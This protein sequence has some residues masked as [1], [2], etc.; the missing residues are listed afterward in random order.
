MY[1]IAN[2]DGVANVYRYAFGTGEIVQITNISTGTTGITFLSPALSVARNTGRVLFSV[3]ESGNYNVYAIEPEEIEPVAVK[4]DA[5]DIEYLGYLT[6]L[7]AVGE[8][9]VENYLAD[10]EDGLVAATEFPSQDYSPRLGLDFIGSTGFGISGGG[11]FGTRVFG[12]ASFFFSDML[13]DH[14]LFTAVQVQGT[15]R[16]IGGSVSYTNLSGR[17]NWGASVSRTPWLSGFTYLE[18]TD[19]GTVI[20][21]R[22]DRMYINR[23][24]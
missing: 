18:Q 16:D 3:F 6:P 8:G 22:L 21:R 2:P 19:Q 14:N 5:E 1:F 13:G 17:F 24:W 10:I 20:N 15:F 7:D 11:P 12:G 9:L 4:K 23:A